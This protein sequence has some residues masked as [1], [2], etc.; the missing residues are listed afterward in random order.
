LQDSPSNADTQPPFVTVA[1]IMS[2]T[3]FDVVA[4]SGGETARPATANRQQ[5]PQLGFVR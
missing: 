4:G 2:D 5:T 3:S 1:Y